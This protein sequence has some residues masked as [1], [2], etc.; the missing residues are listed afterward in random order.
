MA[1]QMSYVE[2]GMKA[3]KMKVAK[4]FGQ[5][6]GEDVAPGRRARSGG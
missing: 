6:E 1:E 3:V 5:S 2:R 4:D